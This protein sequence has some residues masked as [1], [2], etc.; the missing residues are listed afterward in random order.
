M[1]NL[2]FSVL[3]TAL[4][5]FFFCGCAGIDAGPYRARVVY[6]YDGDT[7]K[8]DNEERVR[9]LGIDTPEMNYKNP[10]A[11]YLAEQA[12]EFNSR[13]VKG[14]NVRLEF[15]TVRRDKYNRLLAYVYVDKTF[16]NA[17]LIKAGYA[18]VYIIPPNTKYA[19]DFLS[20][21]RRSKNERKGIW[22]Y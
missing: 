22:A 14:K 7:V 11:E 17:E 20:L 9:Y 19:D 21:Q 1:R 3:V 8:L 4:T 15:D 2:V 16:V 6:V 13:L 12:K 5:P 18:K 10:P